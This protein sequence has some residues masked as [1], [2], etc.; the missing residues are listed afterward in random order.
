MRR[1]VCM[2]LVAF[3]VLGACA[4]LAAAAKKPKL[5]RACTNTLID[6]FGFTDAWERLA[7]D[8]DRVAG[9]DANGVPLRLG[10]LGVL[11]DA[12]ATNEDPTYENNALFDQI[13]QTYTAV[14]DALLDAEHRRCARQMKRLGP[15]AGA[16]LGECAAALKA[17]S[18]ALGKRFPAVF[19]IE[20]SVPSGA[21]GAYLDARVAGGSGAAQIDRLLTA[22]NDVNVA[23]NDFLDRDDRCTSQTATS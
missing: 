8:I 22:I 21:F 7:G 16:P 10:L 13:D 11:L 4:H 6:V 3:V 1:L 17:A 20:E 18:V 23:L 12:N 14:A 9:A 19:G 15:K 2:S 5:P